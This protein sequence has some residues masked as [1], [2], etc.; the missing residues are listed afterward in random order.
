MFT[1]CELSRLLTIP[2]F[3]FHSS[4]SVTPFLRAL[5]IGCEMSYSRA[6]Q[7]EDPYIWTQGCVLCECTRKYV[8][9]SYQHWLKEW[10]QISTLKKNYK[11]LNVQ[12]QVISKYIFGAHIG[13][14]GIQ[15]LPDYPSGGV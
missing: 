12:V 5:A 6:P 4:S 9:K 14:P 13:Q 2:F 3:F 11:C 8:T 1:V 15:P 10:S 7:T